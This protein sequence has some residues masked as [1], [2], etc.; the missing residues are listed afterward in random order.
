MGHDYTLFHIMWIPLKSP[1]A[2]DRR[3]A[4]AK[5]FHI[6]TQISV[7]FEEEDEMKSKNKM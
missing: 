5:P 3:C 2:N 4:S 1:S 7:R 6:L